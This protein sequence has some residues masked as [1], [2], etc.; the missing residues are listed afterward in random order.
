M[1]EAVFK[2]ILHKVRGIE[3]PY[4][5]LEEDLA[6]IRAWIVEEARE[7][8]GKLRAVLICSALL[9][10]HLWVVWD[11]SFEPTDNLAIYFGEEMPLLRGKS[12]G[13]LKL[14]HQTKLIFPGC[15]VVQ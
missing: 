1:N 5:A 3:K 6:P 4:Q 10:A 15:R 13:D 8:N 2:S 9:E 12:M 7:E 11:R 14:I